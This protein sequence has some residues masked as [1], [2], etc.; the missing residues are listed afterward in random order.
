MPPTELSIF[1]KR[2]DLYILE[3]SLYEIYWRL[4][5][6]NLREN[7]DRK[8]EASLHGLELQES[9]SENKKA[10]QALT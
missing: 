8:F 5:Q 2:I 6:I 10:E 9:V 3:L 7:S 1:P 4:N